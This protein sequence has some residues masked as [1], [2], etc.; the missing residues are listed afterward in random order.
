MQSHN[1][2]QPITNYQACKGEKK[3]TNENRPRKQ[4]GDEVANKNIKKAIINVPYVQMFYMFK[5]RKT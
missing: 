3:S 4:K 2:G 1:V 5:K